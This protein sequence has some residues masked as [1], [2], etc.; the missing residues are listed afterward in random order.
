MSK[1]CRIAISTILSAHGSDAETWS[2]STAS[3]LKTLP[4]R[5]RFGTDSLVSWRR[6]QHP[7]LVHYGSYERSFLKRM[8][9]RYGGPAADSIV[10]QALKS[11][12]NLLPFLFLKIYL[13]TY[14]NRLKDTS[15]YFGAT[16]RSPNITG[17]QTIA[18]RCEWERARS[19][20]LKESL[21]AYNQDDCAA[22]ELLSL[23]MK[24]L[25]AESES[26]SDIDFAYTPKKVATESGSGIHHALDGLLKTAWL[27]YSRS[28]I[29]RHKSG[30][31][32]SPT[33]TISSVR[34]KSPRRK[35]P[36]SGGQVIRVPRKRKCPG[37]PDQPTMLRPSS[38]S[39][40][41]CTSGYRVHEDG[42]SEDHCSVSW[43]GK[44]LSILR[45]EICT[46]SSER[47][48]TVSPRQ[49]IPCLGRLFASSVAFV[50][51]PGRKIHP[52]SFSRG[53]FPNDDSGVLP[54]N[55]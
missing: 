31:D 49:R 11:P 5:R 15:A 6:V 2:S 39:S 14:S 44:L 54:A 28:K 21:L 26:R 4:T 43:Q 37:H 52:R 47:S 3:G 42:M 48:S 30:V 35:L 50:L 27:D 22:L 12:V 38:K 25:I 7:F 13:P 34:Q 10:D 55:R 19:V 45:F 41:H 51:S 40:E 33:P 20:R 36:T 32:T 53:H 17:I 9:E 1:G 18:L 23:E 29:K 24:K 16:W 8:C 46:P